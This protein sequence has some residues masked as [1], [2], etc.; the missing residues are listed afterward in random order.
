VN[1]IPIMQL[2]FPLFS[3]QPYVSARTAH[4][5]RPRY[6]SMREMT[7]G[8]SGYRAHSVEVNSLIKAELS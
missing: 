6:D 7:L 5:G 1:I 3:Y 8:N 4:R 2:S